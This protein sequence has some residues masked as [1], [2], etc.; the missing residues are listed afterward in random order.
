MVTGLAV[1]PHDPANRKAVDHS[2]KIALISG[3][4]DNW[5]SLKANRC[6]PYG[7]NGHPVGMKEAYAQISALKRQDSCPSVYD[8]SAYL[9]RS[10]G[11][12]TSGGE[13]AGD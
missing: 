5:L 9:L 10:A 1:D 11:H 6:D 4:E 3:P 8:Q 12:W 2:D 7:H 13:A